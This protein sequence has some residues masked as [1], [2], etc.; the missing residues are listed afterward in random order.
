MRHRKTALAALCLATLGFA[1]C[2]SLGYYW[3]AMRGQMEIS[4]KQRPIADWLTNKSLDQKTRDQLQLIAQIRAFA[5]RELALPDN[6]SYRSYAD[7]GRSYV[8]W[9]VFA[10]PE[11]SNELLQSCFPVAG[12]VTY[13]GFF[14]EE[15]ARV[16]ADAMIKQGHDTYVG[17]V[18]A[19]STL[20]WFNDPVLNTFIQYPEAELARLI[21]HELAHQVVYVKD[22]SMFNESFATAV[23][24]AGIQRWIASRGSAELERQWLRGSERRVQFRG[25]VA[26]YREQLAP[27]YAS[28]LEASAKRARKAEVF[29][30]LKRDYRALVESWG[31]SPSRGAWLKDE[32]NN[33]HLASVA[34]YTEL[35]PAFH[36]LLAQRGGDLRAFYAQ[37]K[38]VAGTDKTQRLAAL[39]GL[40]PAAA[41]APNEVL[42]PK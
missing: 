3:Q 15:K 20:G 22:D 31:E 29:A 23:E 11:F 30:A 24:E 4:T 9:N 25:M 28:A 18:P 1:S 13:R 35:V 41:V 2:S 17:G 12:C 40:L 32:L 27:L 26:R 38:N 19:Y 10:A 39:E 42:A 33:A 36:A 8:L 16:H 34:T 7:L 14:A 37:V 5:T 21:F 6:Q